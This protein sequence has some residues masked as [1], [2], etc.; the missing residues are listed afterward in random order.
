MSKLSPALKALI[1]A[2][3]A[4]PNTLP[5]PPQMRSVYEKLWKDAQRKEV[6]MPA[7]LCLSV[8]SLFISLL[9]PGVGG[10]MS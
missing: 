9:L 6:G 8:S 4:K 7:W 5:A 2:A 1:A 10:R 3:H